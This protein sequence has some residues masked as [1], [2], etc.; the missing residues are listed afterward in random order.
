MIHSKELKDNDIG[1]IILCD[2]ITSQ[3]REALS[4]LGLIED[5]SPAYFFKHLHVDS[6]YGTNKEYSNFLSDENCMYY[7]YTIDFEEFVNTKERLQD[8]NSRFDSDAPHQY[9]LLMFGVA[10]NGKSIE[11]NRRI[12]EKALDLSGNG[13]GYVY[14]DLENAFTEITYGDTYNCP[15]NNALWLFCIKLFDEIMKYIIAHRS[16]CS[17]IL[18]NFNEIIARSNL[19]NNH[20]KQLFNAIGAYYSDND[21][22]TTVFQLIK[23]LLSSKQAN[24]DIKNLLETLMLIMYCTDPNQKQYIVI[25]NIEEYIKLDRHKIQIPNLAITTIYQSVNEVVVNM[26]NAFDRI[27][28]DLGWKAFKIIIVLRRTSLGLLDPSLLQ[29]PARE[30]KNIA[31]ITGYYQISEIWA[32]KKE[33]LW[34]KTLCKRF[35]DS[36][37]EIVIDIVDSLMND[38]P[39]AIGADYQSMIA[40]LMSYGIRRNARAQAHA[41]FKVYKILIETDQKTI[42]YD[43]FLALMPIASPRNAVRYMFRRALIEIQFKWAIENQNRW[44]NLGIGHLVMAKRY[45]TEGKNAVERVA[46]DDPNCVTLMRRIL[47]YLSSY[48]NEHSATISPNRSI[49]DMFETIPLFN[50]IEGVLYNPSRKNKVSDK[51]YLQLAKVLIALSDMSNDDTRSAPYV[52]LGIMDD[53]FHIST[54]ESTLAKL[55]KD[56]YEAGNK[57]SLPYGKY[58]FRDFGARITDAGYSFLLDWHSSFS[59]MAALHCFSIPPLFFLKDTQSAKYVI[60]TVYNASVDLYKKYENEAS[61]FCGNSDDFTLK[62]GFYLPKNR[63]KY[64]TFKQRMKDLH[65]NHLNL[66]KTF[67]EKN[68][69]HL[70]ISENDSQSLLELINDYIGKYSSWETGK[71]A[72][73]CF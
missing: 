16:A 18:K 20:Q 72:P 34:K 17:V 41:A 55:L 28:K 25:D 69:G 14:I 36:R 65:I 7:Q 64:F 39:Q 52:I 73:E 68:Y 32:Q 57:E 30:K 11:V 70:N 31:D 60:K 23:E 53:D 5:V 21:K 38:G 33:Y 63:G 10:G 44:K 3:G 4:N 67:I 40:P 66:Y 61:R 8:F 59:F 37:N 1:D 27:E 54:D 2:P 15:T 6:K 58:N 50:L 71:G 62:T 45:Y 43:E 12:Y 35:D 19:A 46:Y 13:F 48:Y 26:V 51:D 47:T 49:F 42:N 56:I 22:E 24:K 9:P 29:H